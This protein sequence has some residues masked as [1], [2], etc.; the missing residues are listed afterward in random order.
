MCELIKTFT[1]T[2]EIITSSNDMHLKKLVSG[3]ILPSPSGELSYRNVA[4]TATIMTF[5]FR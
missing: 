5:T 1:N 3:F 4:A 2:V